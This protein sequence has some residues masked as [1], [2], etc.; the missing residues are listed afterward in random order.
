MAVMNAS[1]VHP[2][3]AI[4]LSHELSCSYMKEQEISI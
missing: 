2:D 4:D 3:L 1:N